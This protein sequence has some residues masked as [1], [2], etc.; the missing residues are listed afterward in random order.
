MKL[1]RVA[2][3]KILLQQSTCDPNMSTADSWKKTKRKN[4]LASLS[5][6]ITSMQKSPPPHS[7]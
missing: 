5:E 6:Q 2:L 7:T 4:C 3:S 1:Y